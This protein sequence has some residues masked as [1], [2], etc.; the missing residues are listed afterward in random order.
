MKRKVSLFVKDVIDSISIIEG[1]TDKITKEEFLK[2]TLLQ[3]AVIRRLEIIGEAVKN[4]PSE[5]RKNF[6]EVPW[7]LM[8]GMRDV[9]IHD[10][11]GVNLERVWLTT[12]KDLPEVKSKMEVVLNKLNDNHNFP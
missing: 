9:L 8:A 5:V 2:S 1:Y 11:F 4:I 10:Y 3:D 7:K 12:K 6:P